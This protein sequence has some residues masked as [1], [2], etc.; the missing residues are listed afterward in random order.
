MTLHVHPKGFGYGWRPGLP[1]HKFG[2]RR[3]SFIDAASLPSEVDLRPQQPPIYDQGSLGSCTSQAWGGFYEFMAKKAGRDMGTPSRLFIYYNERALNGQAA[4]D[5]GASLADG[6][7]TLSTEG[8]PPE[9]DW[10]YDIARFADEP[11]QSAYND[12]EARLILDPHQVAQDMTTMK[13]V[14][15]NGYNIPIGFT[16]FESFESVEVAATGMVPMPAA[17][18]K[19][20]GGHAVE[21]VGYSDSKSMWIVR[22]SWGIG[23]GQD[24]FCLFPYAYLLSPQ[25]ADD[26]WSATR[27]SG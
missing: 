10:P 9:T 5:A 7:S 1:T 19:Q 6:A 15:A 25:L 20:L 16:V 11:P 4:D 12:G 2:P 22:N 17:S 18:E 13:E 23:W 27:I 8:A 24:G 21:I 26:F 3:Y 14:L